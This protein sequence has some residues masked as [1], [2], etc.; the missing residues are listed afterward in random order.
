VR[1]ETKTY[2]S[3]IA[4]DDMPALERIENAV[5]L[6]FWGEGNYQRFLDAPAECFGCKVSLVA[7]GGTPDIVG[8][9]LARS[10]LE[11]LEILKV[12]VLPELQNRG[13]GTSLMQAAYA[14]GIRRG[15]E[16]CLLEVRKS[17]ENA[18]RFY[19]KEKFRIIGSRQ[20]YYSSPVEDAWVMERDL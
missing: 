11:T 14:E 6:N 3:R 1:T 18:V 10:I 15:C 19:G 16:H 2:I 12:G 7:D 13:L 9:L 5:G 4:P 8:F 17:N 20:D